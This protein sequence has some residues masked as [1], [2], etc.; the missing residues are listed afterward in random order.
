MVA[1]CAPLKREDCPRVQ[2]PHVAV[3][4]RDADLLVF[5]YGFLI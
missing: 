1:S 2:I 4:R 5:G 3:D